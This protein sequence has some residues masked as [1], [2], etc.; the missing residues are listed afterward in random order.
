MILLAIDSFSSVLSAAVSVKDEI[1]FS[2]ADAPMRQS[3]LVMD[4]IDDLLKKNSLKPDDLNGVLCMGGPGSFTGL[5]IGYSI[6]KAL[7]LSLSIPFAPVPTLDCVAYGNSNLTLALVNARKDTF[8]YA[9]YKNNE[10]LT[11][12]KEAEA[13]YIIK[14][15]FKYKTENEKLVL[16]GKGSS[17]FINSIPQDLKE[18]IELNYSGKGYAEELILIAK[19]KKIFEND[20]TEYLYSGPDYLRNAI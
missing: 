4:L 1:H 18:N 9:F 14:E 13:D 2:Q 20:C 11:E 16:T 5:R 12:D 15:I 8:F 7:A 17:I 3:E 19:N 6:G 10:K